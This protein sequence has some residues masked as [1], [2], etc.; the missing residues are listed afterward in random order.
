MRSSSTRLVVLL[1]QSVPGALGLALRKSSVSAAARRVRPQCRL[2]AERRAS[3]SAQDP[4]RRQR[5]HRRQL[6][7]RRQGRVERGHPHRERRLHRPQHDP[8]VQE[9]RHRAGRR[10][11]HRL[12][13]RDFFREP[14]ADRA[15]RADRRLLLSHRRRSRLQRCLARP[16]SNRRGSRPASRSAMAR[17]WARARRCS[18]ASRLAPTRSIGAGA[19]VRESVP[20]RATAVGVPARSC[21]SATR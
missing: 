13:L 12:Q 19:V 8:V 15:K 3:P 2:R 7:H 11:E 18:M 6:P 5:G 16:C 14:R 9:R 10:R 1:S 20:E 21:A 17:G 4:H